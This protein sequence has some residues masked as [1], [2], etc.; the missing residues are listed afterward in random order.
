MPKVIEL[1]EWEINRILA[2]LAEKPYNEVAGIIKRI[3]EQLE[4]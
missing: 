3:M 2:I 1:Q 4:V